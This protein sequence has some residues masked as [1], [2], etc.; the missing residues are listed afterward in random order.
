MRTPTRSADVN[1]QNRIKLAADQRS[2]LRQPFISISPTSTATSGLP[3]APYWRNLTGWPQGSEVAARGEGG[4]SRHWNSDEQQPGEGQDAATEIY[5]R[6]LDVVRA[7]VEAQEAGLRAYET[8]IAAH[9]TSQRIGV[10]PAVVAT[11][12]IALTT[13]TGA[14][15][16]AIWAIVKAA[17]RLTQMPTARRRSPGVPTRSKIPKP[18]GPSGFRATSAAIGKAN[19]R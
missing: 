5:S 2:D 8:M 4:P 3:T 17:A 7:S 19:T 9:A 18:G 12:G 15:G 14:H 1:G 6:G 10:R 11:T 13:C 16:S